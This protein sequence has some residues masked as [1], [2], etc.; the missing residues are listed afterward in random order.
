MSTIFKQG[1]EYVDKIQLL[2]CSTLYIFLS[3][4]QIY[5]LFLLL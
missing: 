4:K 2:I 3:F 1:I 5:N